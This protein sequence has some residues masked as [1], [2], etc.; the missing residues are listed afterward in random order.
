MWNTG[1]K[2][3]RAEV[4]YGVS[5]QNVEKWL[6]CATFRREAAVRLYTPVNH[7]PAQNAF[8]KQHGDPEMVETE[9]VTPGAERDTGSSMSMR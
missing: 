6:S 1:K 9:G 7:E 2:S 5:D 3:S 8:E 4:Q